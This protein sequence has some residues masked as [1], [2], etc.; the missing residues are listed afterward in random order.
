MATKDQFFKVLEET[1]RSDEQQ[2]SAINAQTAVVGQLQIEI[3]ALVTTAQQELAVKQERLRLEKEK[4]EAKFKFLKILG[5]STGFG[6]VLIY[7][8]QLVAK[9][10]G[11][12]L[13]AVP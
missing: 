6:L 7:L 12:D 9:L 3:K 10:C 11:Y 5:G 4:I 8:I 2:T 13:P 1:A